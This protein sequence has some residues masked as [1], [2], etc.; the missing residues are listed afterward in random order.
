MLG[1]YMAN[2]WKR[3]QFGHYS[4]LMKKLRLED[5]T[6]FFNYFRMGPRMFGEL[7]QR[8]GPGIQ[9]TDTNLG[10]QMNRQWRHLAANDKYP[11]RQFDFRVFR[12]TI[13]KIIPDVCQT[14]VRVFKDEFIQPSKRVATNY[15]IM[16]EEVGCAYARGALPNLVRISVAF[17]LHSPSLIATFL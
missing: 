1:A 9:K 6:S 8:V 17:A 16:P 3:F 4:Q 5:T 14:I 2:C 12:I 13:T 7:L 11:T 10:E 15:W